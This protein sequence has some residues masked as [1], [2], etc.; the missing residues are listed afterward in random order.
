MASDE[1]CSYGPELDQVLLGWAAAVGSGEDAS[2]LAVEA[3]GHRA[4][5]LGSGALVELRFLQR[6]VSCASG[7]LGQRRR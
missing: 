5:C 1:L 7:P 3:H 4:A 2:F 6:R